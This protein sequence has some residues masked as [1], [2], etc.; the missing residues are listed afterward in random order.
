MQEG[1]D[2]MKVGFIGAGRMGFTLGKHLAMR[3]N[4]EVIG[5]YS[6][7]K[8]SAIQ[9]A[10]FTD[11]KYYE[12][13]EQL[14]ADSDAL[15]LTVPDG[16]IAV[17]ADMLDRL[18]ALTD[19]KILCHTS[20]ALS[21]QVLSGIHSQVY[22]YSIHPIYAVNSKLTS[23]ES[24]AQCFIT[25]EGDERYLSFWQD[26]FAQIGHKTKT[27]VA[28]DKVKYHSSAVF[29]SNLV[30]GLYQ[31]ATDLLMRCGFNKEEASIALSTLFLDN[32][33]NIATVGAIEA[34][35]G[36]VSRCD[37][38]TVQKHLDVL[39]GDYKV[40]YQVLSRRLINIA[41]QQTFAPLEEGFDKLELY[42]NDNI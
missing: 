39:E 28:E 33:K 2:S 25:I 31:M 42:L 3:S 13:F 21:S 27:I 15:F 11:T 1:G 24:F 41:K 7:S 32:A 8:E 6:K 34:L 40:A 10:K 19:G 22:G 17:M 35:T 30:V 20:G 37:I 4:L 5:Y 26:V 38:T 18:G 29:A 9:A 14:V 16:Q 23:Y 36:P 12:D